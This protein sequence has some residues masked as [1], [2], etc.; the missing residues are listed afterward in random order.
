M[1]TDISGVSSVISG[2]LSNI[3]SNVATVITTLIALFSMSPHLAAVGILVIPLLILPTRT[4][5]RT[6][7]RLQRRC[8]RRPA[9]FTRPNH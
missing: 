2:T 9:D 1:N 5:G 8:T 4:A 6:R 7:R 3:V